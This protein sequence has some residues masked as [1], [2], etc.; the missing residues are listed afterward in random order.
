MFVT[1]SRKGSKDCSFS[2][3]RIDS[4]KGY[5]KGNVWIISHKANTM[6][7]ASTLEEFLLMA[8]NWKL[9]KENNYDLSDVEPTKHK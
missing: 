6:K 5:I 3:D 7:S 4:S 2:L 1:E 8:Q 9:W